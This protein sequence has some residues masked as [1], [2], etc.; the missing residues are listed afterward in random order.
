MSRVPGRDD[1]QVISTCGYDH[2]DSCVIP[3]GVTV[4]PCRTTQVPGRR[5]GDD[6]IGSCTGRRTVTRSTARARRWCRDGDKTAGPLGTQSR[7]VPGTAPSLKPVRALRAQAG[8]DTR[9]LLV[10]D[11]GRQRRER[12]AAPTTFR[13]GH[14]VCE[15]YRERISANYVVATPDGIDRSQADGGH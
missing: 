2:K 13:G 9:R 15:S 4:A 10:R 12:R 11:C 6:V 5:S 3:R 7:P 8:P 1:T 14:V